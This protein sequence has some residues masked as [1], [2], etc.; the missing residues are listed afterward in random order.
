MTKEISALDQVL[1]DTI[2]KTTAT[3]GQIVDGV[4]KV[5]S[6]AID[7]TMAQIPD[8]IHQLLMW[9]LVFS[10]LSFLLFLSLEITLLLIWY[11]KSYKST[12]EEAQ[13][14]GSLI[15]VIVFFVFLVQ[16]CRSFEWLQ[17]W[18]APK[19]WL[20]EYAASLMS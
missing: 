8:V 20:I 14:F 10:L 3:T 1:I 17:I 2:Q 13:F 18:I 12:Y 19:V 6:K 16:L 4:G 5:T 11:Y 15:S 9:H 7:F